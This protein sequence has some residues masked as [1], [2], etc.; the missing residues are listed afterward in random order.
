MTV[1]VTAWP[2][3]PSSQTKIGGHQPQI[4][5]ISFHLEDTHLGIKANLAVPPEEPLQHAVGHRQLSRSRSR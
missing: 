1:D 5:G 3:A 4:V 2:R